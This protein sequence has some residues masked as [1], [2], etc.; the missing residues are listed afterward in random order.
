MQGY[1][2]SRHHST[3]QQKQVWIVYI[4]CMSAFSSVTIWSSWL[5]NKRLRPTLNFS[6]SNLNKSDFICTTLFIHIRSEKQAD[7]QLSPALN[8]SPPWPQLILEMIISLWYFIKGKLLKSNLL[9]LFW[10]F[11]LVEGGLQSF[12]AISNFM[13]IC[14]WRY[15]LR[16]VYQES[17]TLLITRYFLPCESAMLVNW[18]ISFNIMFYFHDEIHLKKVMWYGTSN[19]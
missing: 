10:D 17:L 19:V 4:T 18:A 6:T 12:P 8:I 9:L 3:A 7:K 16:T 14:C 13:M 2:S 15:I 11:N 1:C 5:N